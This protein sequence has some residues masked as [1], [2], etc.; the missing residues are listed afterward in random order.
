V[1]YAATP[2]GEVARNI[3]VKSPAD[4]YFFNG[5]VDYALTRDQVLP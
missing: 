4:N 3:P 2:F 1:L 5:G